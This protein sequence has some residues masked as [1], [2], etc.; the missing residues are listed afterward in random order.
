MQ[1]WLRKVRVTLQGTGGSYVINP[2]GVQQHEI[3]VAFSVSRNIS[4]TPNEGTITIYNLAQEHRE[5][6][7]REFDTVTLEAGYENNTGVIFMG[8]IRDLEHQAR[9]SVQNTR[10]GLDILTQIN[11]GDGDSALRRAVISKTFPAGSTVEEITEGIYTELEA[12]GLARGEWM[13]PEDVLKYKRP[14][15]VWGTAFKELNLLGRSHRFYWSVQN[16][17]VEIIPHD[18]ALPGTIY[19]DKYTGLI[20]APTITDNGIKVRA[21]LNPAARPNRTV[22][23]QSTIINL[24]NSTYRISEVEFYGDNHK[25]S[26]EMRIT[27]ETLRGGTVDEGVGVDALIAAAKKAIP[28]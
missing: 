2:G 19:L 22:T 5:A 7:G 17:A 14:Y 15:S 11:V 13:L 10:S 16:G 23:V 1:N 20:E 3:K 24:T 6:I 25:G 8:Q 18:G 12:Q 27:G 26:F 28:V 4:S 9:E 21:L